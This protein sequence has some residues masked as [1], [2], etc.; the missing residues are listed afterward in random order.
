MLIGLLWLY[1]VDDAIV[2]MTAHK[3]G[4]ESTEVRPAGSSTKGSRSCMSRC[5][6]TRLSSEY[7][8]RSV[9]CTKF[10]RIGYAQ[11]ATS[12]L[13]VVAARCSLMMFQKAA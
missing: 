3:L 2:A 13:Q 1:C 6:S 5:L 9:N 7:E 11:A 10:D 8:S 12:L 4:L